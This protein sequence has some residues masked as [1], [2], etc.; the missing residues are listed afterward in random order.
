MLTRT[1]AWR[2]DLGEVLRFAVA[3]VVVSAHEGLAGVER[4]LVVRKM[5]LV[6][7]PKLVVR[8]STGVL[9]HG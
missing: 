5:S 4:S 8:G 1:R 6:M 9:R 3:G 7:V 2:T